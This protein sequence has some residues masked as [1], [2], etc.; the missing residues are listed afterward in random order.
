MLAMTSVV[1]QGPAIKT[2]TVAYMLDGVPME[3]Y[4]AYD[5]AKKGP[6]PGILIVH[7]WMGEGK[8]DKDK[9]DILAKEG[10]VAFAVDIYGKGVRPMDAGEAGKLATKF[11]DDR[12]LLRARVRAGLE[13]LTSMPEVDPKK[14]VV[15][16]YCFGGT[17]ALE[18]AR[19]GASWLAR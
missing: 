17:T 19:S 2:K 9:A 7:D 12:K 11:K 14:V 4:V 5:E 8:F 13:K 10:Y 6:R 3:G 16:G 1:A 18:L 15:M